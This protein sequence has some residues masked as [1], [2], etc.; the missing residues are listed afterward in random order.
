M[1][2]EREGTLQP[3]ISPRKGEVF[4]ACAEDSNWHPAARL[5]LI[6]PIMNLITLS[7]MKISVLRCTSST[8][9]KEKC[10][11][12]S[13]ILFFYIELA[14]LIEEVERRKKERKRI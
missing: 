7:W 14:H 8:K 12:M 1:T 11:E 5:C 9:V 4:R 3:P 13:C 2:R 10:V 6:H